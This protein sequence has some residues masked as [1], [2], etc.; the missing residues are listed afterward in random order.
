MPPVSGVIYNADASGETATSAIDYETDTTIQR[1]LR[2]AVGAD[3]TVLT[4][5]H[6]LQTIMDADKVVRTFLD[7]GAHSMCNYCEGCDHDVCVHS[8]CWIRVGS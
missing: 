6:R 8:S 7:F 1:S 5:A 4:I 2:S 3:V